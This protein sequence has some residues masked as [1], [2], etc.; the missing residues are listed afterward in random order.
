M[1]DAAGRRRGK[2]ALTTG[3]GTLARG[4]S[5]ALIRGWASP[6]VLGGRNSYATDI[7]PKPAAAATIRV[8]AVTD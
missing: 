1:M 2:P 3:Q 5:F 4:L 6:V 8:G 7:T